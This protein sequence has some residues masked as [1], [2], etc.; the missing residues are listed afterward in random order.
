[1]IG[2]LLKL[3]TRPIIALVLGFL[4]PLIAQINPIVGFFIGFL[5]FALA[6]WLIADAI[7]KLSHV[8][9]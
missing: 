1:M 9:I 5:S 4:A 2:F 3:I 6:L 7:E 8:F